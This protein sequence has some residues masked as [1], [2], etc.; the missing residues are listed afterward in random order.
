MLS[1]ILFG[2]AVFLFIVGGAYLRWCNY[3]QEKEADRLGVRVFSRFRW[4]TIDDND[5]KCTHEL[6]HAYRVTGLLM[7]VNTTLFVFIAWITHKANW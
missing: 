6:G 5:P 1:K 7:T 2:S 3:Q 4:T